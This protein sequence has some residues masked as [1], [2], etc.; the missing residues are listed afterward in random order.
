MQKESNS[1]VQ[2]PLH[3]AI[4]AGPLRRTGRCTLGLCYW[5][6]LNKVDTSKRECQCFLCLEGVISLQGALLPSAPHRAVLPGGR[7]YN[8]KWR[9]V[10][11]WFPHCIEVEGRCEK[12]RGEKANLLCLQ[13]NSLNYTSMNICFTHLMFINNTMCEP[14]QMAQLVSFALFWKAMVEKAQCRAMHL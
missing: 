8:A 4:K 5:S 6:K 13:H 1:C 12:W 11:L 9:A 3:N 14:K 7:W 2:G 10:D